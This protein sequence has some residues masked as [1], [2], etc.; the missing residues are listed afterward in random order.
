MKP[1]GL[2][3]QKGKANGVLLA[4]ITSRRQEGL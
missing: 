1:M 4:I 3:G 2:N